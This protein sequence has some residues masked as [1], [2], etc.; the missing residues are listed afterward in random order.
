VPYGER[1]SSLAH[2][3]HYRPDRAWAD[4]IWERSATTLCVNPTGNS[5]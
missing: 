1:F 5:K 2:S 4:S 3:G